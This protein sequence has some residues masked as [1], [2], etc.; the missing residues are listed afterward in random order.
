MPAK[1]MTITIKVEPPAFG[2]VILK[3]KEMPGIVGFDLDLSDS[4]ATSGEPAALPQQQGNREEIITAL[5]IKKGGPVNIDEMHQALTLGGMGNGGRKSVYGVIHTLKRKGIVKGT[6]EKGTI[7]LTAKARKSIKGHEDSAIRLLPKPRANGK[8]PPG[9]RLQKNEGPMRLYRFIAKQD[10][11]VGRQRIAEFL[12]SVGNSAKSMAGILDRGKQGGLL[13]SAGAGLY[14]L[15]AKGKAL[16][17][18]NTNG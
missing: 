4:K 15:T 12:V 8:H 3:L 14:E 5:L 9:Q 13:K 11:P 1:L 10:G 18:E 17:T 16:A 7:E 6:G 2:P